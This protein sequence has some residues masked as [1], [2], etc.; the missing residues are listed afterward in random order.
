MRMIVVL[1]IAHSINQAGNPEVNWFQHG[2]PRLA[3]VNVHDFQRV[4]SSDDDTLIIVF[5]NDT[6]IRI[7]GKLDEFLTGASKTKKKAKKEAI[8]WVK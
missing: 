2:E 7:K 6:A 4:Y 8:E 1:E 3:K 5:K